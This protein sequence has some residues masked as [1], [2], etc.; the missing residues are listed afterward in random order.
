MKGIIVKTNP[1][2]SQIK[3]IIVNP[4]IGGFPH[5]ISPPK[6]AQTNLPRMR[7]SNPVGK[8]ANRIDNDK[9]AKTPTHT[10]LLTTDFLFHHFLKSTIF[11]K[12]MI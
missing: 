5:P 12:I 1:Q 3:N 9:E 4:T 2:K 7:D 10:D 6:V 8:N 11:S